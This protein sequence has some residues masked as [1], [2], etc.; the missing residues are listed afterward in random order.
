[1]KPSASRRDPL[2]SVQRGRTA[3]DYQIHRPVVEKRFEVSIDG[4]TIPLAQLRRL[5]VVVSIERR[6]LYTLNFARRTRVRLADTA[7]TNDAEVF[8]SKV[9]AAH[10]I[11]RRTCYR[12]VRREMFIALQFVLLLALL[13]SE[14]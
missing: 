2:L 4:A 10:I 3:N 8:H 6:N 14:M 11:T 13:R 9:R 5:F 1:M 7:T 12:A